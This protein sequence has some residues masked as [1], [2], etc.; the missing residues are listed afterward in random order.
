MTFTGGATRF[1]ILAIFVSMASGCGLFDS[2]IVTEYRTVEDDGHV[3]VEND[4]ELEVRVN[5]NAC[6]SGS[7]DSVEDS[8]CEIAVDAD[9]VT[10]TSF[11][12]IK[13]EYE[14]GQGCTADC[15]VVS[16]E[17]STDALE[18]GEYTVVHG[19]HTMTLTIPSADEICGAG[20]S[21]I[22]PLE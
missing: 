18:D 8:G 7:C 10:V 22:D 12:E 11:L 14:A 13:T 21:P 16:T 6:L 20:E 4:E 19:D 17:C 3:C 15:G 1:G 9:T 2:E 5:F